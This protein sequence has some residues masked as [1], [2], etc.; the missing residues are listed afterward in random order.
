MHTIN[1]VMSNRKDIKAKASRQAAESARSTGL[2][3][4][5]LFLRIHP[6]LYEKLTRE[7]EARMVSIKQVVVE[8]LE[9]R[10]GRPAT[11]A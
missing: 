4:V 2:E 8:A 5:P 1:P 10:F 9:A 3:R 6:Q 7:S 11:A